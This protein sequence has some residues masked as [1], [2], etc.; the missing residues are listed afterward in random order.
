MIMRAE[1]TMSGAYI[2]EGTPYEPLQKWRPPQCA[3]SVL[4]HPSHIAVSFCSII[5]GFQAIASLV[6]CSAL[7]NATGAGRCFTWIDR[8]SL[9]STSQTSAER[10]SVA[11]PTQGHRQLYHVQTSREL[12]RGK[13]IYRTRTRRFGLDCQKTTWRRRRGRA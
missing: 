7:F 4:L 3:F 9:L 12:C 1:T 8:S 13:G 5:F 6:Q 10:A 11:A 2:A